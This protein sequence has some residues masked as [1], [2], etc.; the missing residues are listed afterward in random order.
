MASQFAF[1]L[2]WKWFASFQQSS[3]FV[4]SQFELLSNS[5][6]NGFSSSSA[7]RKISAP[8]PLPVLPPPSSAQ[9]VKR[10]ER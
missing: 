8:C 3:L 1:V 10:N 2:P 4:F 9:K 7:H 5:D 6:A